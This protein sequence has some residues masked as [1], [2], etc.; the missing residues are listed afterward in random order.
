M[1]F[2]I[3]SFP[4]PSSSSA[5]PAKLFRFASYS[6]P[7]PNQSS[8]DFNPKSKSDKC[9]FTFEILSYCN[10]KQ[11]H[12]MLTVFGKNIKL[13]VHPNPLESLALIQS[14]YEAVSYLTRVEFVND[15]ES[16]ASIIKY[17]CENNFHENYYIFKLGNDNFG[18]IFTKIIY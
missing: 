11:L 16:Y 12:N 6:K 10:L 8:K 7:S 14:F 4:K 5:S 18:K 15:L 13:G 1:K 17:L 2:I 9:E 3:P